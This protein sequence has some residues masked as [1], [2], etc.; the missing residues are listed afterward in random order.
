MV[1][2]RQ[3]HEGVVACVVLA[4]E[5]TGVGQGAG[6]DQGAQVGPGF[7]LLHKNRQQLARSRILHQP[8]ERLQAAERQRA[9]PFVGPDGREP[10]V[11]GQ[12]RADA[13]HQHA[14]ADIR[15][16]FSSIPVSHCRNP[17]GRKERKRSRATSFA[18]RRPW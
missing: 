9:L 1:G 13:G 4:A 8:H 12:G 3:R 5:G 16:K 10:Q 15:Q 6:R 17:P 2:G 7:H 11:A 18:Q 14:P